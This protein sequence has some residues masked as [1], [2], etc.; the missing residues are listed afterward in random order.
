MLL[1]LS[2]SVC[3]GETD[4]AV[5]SA[6]EKLHGKSGKNEDGKIDF[7]LLVEKGGI[8]KLADE[9]VES[10]EFAALAKRARLYVIGRELTDRSLAQFAKAPD[11]NGVD[12]IETKITDKGLTTF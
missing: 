7:V 11:L 4:K 3:A 2:G 9:D 6:I 5:A 12:L 1:G 10:I 8:G